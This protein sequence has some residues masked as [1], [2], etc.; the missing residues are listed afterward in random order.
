MMKNQEDLA[1]ISDALG[2]R[3]EGAVVTEPFAQWVIEEIKPH[4]PDCAVNSSR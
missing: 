2:A 3:D 4:L 1:R